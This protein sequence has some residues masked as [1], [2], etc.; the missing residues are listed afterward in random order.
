MCTIKQYQ[1]IKSRDQ[2]E[3]ESSIRLTMKLISSRD[4][5]WQQQ[6]VN[7]TGLPHSWMS[8]SA[9]SFRAP[10]QRGAEFLPFKN[11]CVIFF[12]AVAL[13]RSMQG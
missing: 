8:Q 3:A 7:L 9:R 12:F 10:A 11:R 13:E 2:A 4:T 6:S 5:R 1:L